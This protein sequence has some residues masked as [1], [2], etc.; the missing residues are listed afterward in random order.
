VAEL[1]TV[2]GAVYDPTHTHNSGSGGAGGKEPKILLDKNSVLEK[3]C[4]LI[5]AYRGLLVTYFPVNPKKGLKDSPPPNR[6]VVGGG[7]GKRVGVG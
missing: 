4:K 5:L 1:I 7:G 2:R 6:W 3:D